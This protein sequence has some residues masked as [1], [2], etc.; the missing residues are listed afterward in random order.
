MKSLNVCLILCIALLST[1]NSFQFSSLLEV[2]ELKS[3]I[4]GSNLIETISLTF[5][6]EDRVA[7]GKEVL[8]ML[9]DLKGQLSSDQAN[10]TS[11]FEAKFEEFNKHIE[12]LTDEINQL[13]T[14]IEDLVVE[15]ARLTGLI[16]QADKNIAAFKDR[17]SNL[18]TL[19]SQVTV[20][21]QND[22]KYYNEKISELK[23]V[24]AAFGQVIEK[25]QKLVGSISAVGIYSHINMTDSEKRDT[26]WAQA[27]MTPEAK[28]FLQIESGTNE[29]T[30]MIKKLSK[31][32]DN[33]LEMT[34]TADQAALNKLITILTAIQDETLSQ[35]SATETH[36]NDINAQFAE[37]K[38]N[39]EDE[40]ALNKQSLQKQEEN[41]LT[42]I[43]QKA[44]A[45]EEKAAKERRRDLL[46]NERTINEDLRGKLKQ[47]HDKEKEERAGEVEVVDKLMKIVENRLIN[48]SF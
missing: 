2:Q 23:R 7:A 14:E 16:A 20:A 41:R 43:D 47:T 10:D 37:L 4:F 17:I 9:N 15:I 42:Y 8:T 32:Y 1:I 26:E 18:D 34:V 19:L 24:Y 13:Q 46:I 28:S 6:N 45:E 38:K 25:L 29:M 27:N 39:V 44:K 11:L 40:I 5:Q 30:N 33:F 12:K 22:N 21:N 35:K 31:Q 3:S 48:R 36:L